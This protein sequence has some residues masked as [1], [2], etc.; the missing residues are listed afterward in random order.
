MLYTW[1]NF[2]I[3]VTDFDVASYRLESTFLLFHNNTSVPLFLFRVRT[4]QQSQTVVP[5]L[6]FFH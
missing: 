1:F 4:A 3:Y 5:F 6:V 2:S